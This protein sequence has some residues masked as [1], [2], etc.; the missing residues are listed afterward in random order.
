MRL[1]LHLTGLIMSAGSL[2]LWPP[3]GSSHFKEHTQ[4]ADR[5]PSLG[6]ILEIAKEGLFWLP[7]PDVPLGG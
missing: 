2:G 1:L 4:Y 5:F 3:Y 6:R 7:A